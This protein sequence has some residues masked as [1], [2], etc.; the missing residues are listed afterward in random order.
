MQALLCNQV[1]CGC[2]TGTLGCKRLVEGVLTIRITGTAAP[3]EVNRC[4]GCG[5]AVVETYRTSNAMTA[6]YATYAEVA[7]RDTTPPGVA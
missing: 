3:S 1:G 6:T 7:A 2:C 4:T 5:R